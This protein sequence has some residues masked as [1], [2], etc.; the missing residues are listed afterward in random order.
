RDAD[1]LDSSKHAFLREIL[2]SI[3]CKTCACN[4]PFV[5]ILMDNIALLA[6]DY[7]G[8]TDRFRSATGVDSSP[9][10][11]RR[12]R[13]QSAVSRAA[14]K[15]PVGGPRAKRCCRAQFHGARSLAGFRTSPPFPP[16]YVV[17]VGKMRHDRN[18]S[19]LFA[20]EVIHGHGILEKR[21]IARDHG[22]A[23]LGY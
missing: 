3:A 5:A 6:D 2:R 1:K 21:I 15:N 22:D 10:G 19:G 8:N 18:E 16:R 23:A 4:Q 12:V 7:V 20:G 14:A 17:W 13:A 9:W 11:S